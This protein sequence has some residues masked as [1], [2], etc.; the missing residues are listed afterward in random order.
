MN[1]AL[2]CLGCGDIYFMD[3]MIMRHCIFC[4]SRYISELRGDERF[5]PPAYRCERCGARRH[6]KDGKFHTLCATC[7]TVNKKWY[8]T[9]RICKCCKNRFRNKTRRGIVFCN[10]ILCSVEKR[11]GANMMVAR[12]KD[13]HTAKEWKDMLDTHE[14][15]C[16]YC[17]VAPATTKD[18]I[19]PVSRGGSNG[20]QNIAPACR[21]CNSSK[22][23]RLLSEWISK[24]SESEP[25]ENLTVPPKLR[26]I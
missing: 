12:M 7:S 16:V 1:R 9:L 23:N 15:I 24:K 13:T 22:G 11:R 21:A 6:V 4:Y 26:V 17:Q 18:H 20:I 10:D 19:V 8:A 2:S 14:G 5:Y 3:D 25:D